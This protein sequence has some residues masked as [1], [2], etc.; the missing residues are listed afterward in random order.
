MA[1]TIPELTRLR[2]E[3]AQGVFQTEESLL[4]AIN[5]YKNIVKNHISTV[6]GGYEPEVVEEYLKRAG[7][8]LDEIFKGKIEF[9]DIGNEILKKHKIKKNQNS[10]YNFLG[11]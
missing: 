10:K 5:E 3:F 2:E 6:L 11:G 4:Q 7:F 9:S 8:D 1:V